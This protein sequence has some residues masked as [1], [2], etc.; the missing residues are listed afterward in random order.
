MAILDYVESQLRRCDAPS[1]LGQFHHLLPQS[2]FVTVAA[3]TWPNGTLYATSVGALEAAT[4]KETRTAHRSC[5]I[6]PKAT[7]NVSKGRVG[8]VPMGKNEGEGYGGAMGIHVNM[9]GRRHAL[10]TRLQTRLAEL[11]AE[12]SALV[13]TINGASKQARAKPSEHNH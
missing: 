10:T 9:S 1:L 6:F 4:S 2:L 5:G 3:A 7:Q 8:Q 11:F 12:D 13:S